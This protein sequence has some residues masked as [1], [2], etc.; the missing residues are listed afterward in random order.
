MNDDSAYCA[1][2]SDSLKG[3]GPFGISFASGAK[4]GPYVAD[5]ALELLSFLQN[6]SPTYRNKSNPAHGFLPL[7]IYSKGP[8][9]RRF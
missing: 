1:S 3:A 7:H 5:T 6:I 4:G 2:F 8:T 9:G